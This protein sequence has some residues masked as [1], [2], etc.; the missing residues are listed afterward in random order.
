MSHTDA[1]ALQANQQ[2]GHARERGYP[3]DPSRRSERITQIQQRMNGEI[4]DGGQRDDERKYPAKPW[5]IDR[6]WK[7]RRFNPAIRCA[8]D[9][10][11][12]LR[13]PET[14]CGL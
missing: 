1:P 7:L 9:D 5:T 12:R 4:V 14:N 11:Q 6:Y 3:L 2:E 10:L 13:R 8:I